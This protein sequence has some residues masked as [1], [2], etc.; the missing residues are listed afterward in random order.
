M[1]I[2]RLV[3]TVSLLA[4]VGGCAD[5]MAPVPVTEEYDI[6]YQVQPGTGLILESLTDLPVVGEIEVNQVVITELALN[7]VGGIEAAGNITFIV[8]ALGE[9]VTEDFTTEVIISRSGTGNRCD[10][11]TVDLA[12]ITADVIGGVEVDLPEADLAARGSGPVGSLLCVVGRIVEGLAPL[13]ALTGILN[14]LNR[15]I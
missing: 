8:N 7:A 1:K 5:S 2:Q 10:V 6:A 11:V 14:A 12:P 4:A 3:L 15:I 9:T 13:A